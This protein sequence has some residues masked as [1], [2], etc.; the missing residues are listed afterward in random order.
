MFLCG[1]AS[2]RTP[3]RHCMKT[4]LSCWFWA[5]I[6]THDTYYNWSASVI[7]EF[8]KH[9]GC[10]GGSDPFHNCSHFAATFVFV[11]LTFAVVFLT[12]FPSLNV[13]MIGRKGWR[14]CLRTGSHQAGGGGVGNKFVGCL[15]VRVRSEMT[16]SGLGLVKAGNLSLDLNGPSCSKAGGTL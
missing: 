1:E 13:E 7:G 5:F 14:T 12:A 2:L 4:S 15:L 6:V 10:R 11:G 9:G 8:V 16:S 3:Q